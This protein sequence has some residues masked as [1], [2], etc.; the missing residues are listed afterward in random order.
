VIPE[1]RKI[2]AAKHCVR[3][4]MSGGSLKSILKTVGKVLGPLAKEL[5][6]TVLKEFVIP[7]LKQQI[8]LGLALPG[9]GALRLAGQRRS[10]GGAK[11]KKRLY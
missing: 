9:G 6:P 11:K 4:Q 1:Q 10:R 3:A 8:G 7:I 2:A 5:G